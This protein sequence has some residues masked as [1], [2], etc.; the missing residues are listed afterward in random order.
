MENPMPE[1][2]LVEDSRLFG[3][4]IKENLETELPFPV[5]WYKTLTETKEALKNSQTDYLMGIVDL[6][7]PDAINGEIMDL[8]LSNNIPPIVMTGDISEDVRKTVWSRDVVDYVAKQTPRFAKYITGLVKRIYKNRL[9]KILV[10]DDSKLFRN[11]VTNLL[12]IHNY[13]IIEAENGPSA[14]DQVEKN[15]DIKM[16]ITDFNMPE[17]DGIVLTSKLRENHDK[18]EMAIIGIS[19]EGSNLMSALFIKSGAN[20]FLVKPFLSEEFYLRVN[21]NIEVIEYIEQIKALSNQDYLTG[22]FNRRYFF[23]HASVYYRNAKSEEHTMTTVVAM[24]DIDKFKN[25]NDTYGHDSGDE[26]LRH[27]SALLKDHFTENDIVSRFGGEEFC[28][29]ATFFNAN[30][31]LLS[32]ENLR[33]KVEKSNVRVG[34]SNIGYTISTGLCFNLMNS[35]DE[36]INK[37]DMMLYIAK[38]EG[39]NR[40]RTY[41]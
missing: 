34:E 20:D 15:P 7:L 39:R 8:V 10:V 11:H 22:L 41:G 1:I 38:R 23:K 2:L 19:A 4:M 18:D 33:E 37:S 24:I 40:I 36:M 9:I 3:S 12:K 21:Q 32:F 16:V 6:H 13:Q 5:S 31:A 30:Q 35:L 26:V 29:L 14:I 27:L 28:I 17:M 25:I